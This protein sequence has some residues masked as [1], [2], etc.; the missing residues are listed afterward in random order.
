MGCLPWSDPTPL[1]DHSGWVASSLS[2]ILWG[3]GK[4]WGRGPVRR[5][6]LALTRKRREGGCMKPNEVGDDVA[7]VVSA[8]CCLC[9][10]DRTRQTKVS[11]ISECCRYGQHQQAWS[12]EDCVM[13]LVCVC[14]TVCVCVCVCTNNGR[15]QIEGDRGRQMETERETKRRTAT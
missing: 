2:S 13:N 9:P 10:R 4:Q 12:S 11:T 6:I 8:P 3:R 5:P 14:V 15:Q 1:R 7:A